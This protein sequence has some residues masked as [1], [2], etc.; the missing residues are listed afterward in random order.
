MVFEV[1]ETIGLEVVSVKPDGFEVQEYVFP[2]TAVEPMAAVWPKQIF[3]VLIVFA[4]GSGFT[5][6]T[7]ESD[8]VQPVEV[9]FSVR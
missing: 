6:I 2:V 1:G 4:K 3:C 8:F 5:V 9:I 7:T